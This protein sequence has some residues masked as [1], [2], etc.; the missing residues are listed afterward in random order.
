MA[1]ASRG[2][3]WMR[4]SFFPFSVATASTAHFYHSPF[5]KIRRRPSRPHPPCRP[6]KKKCSSTKR[7]SGACCKKHTPAN[8]KRPAKYKYNKKY[9]IKTKK[10]K[11]SAFQPYALGRPKKPAPRHNNIFNN[12]IPIL[13]MIS[14]QRTIS[15]VPY[16][17]H[18]HL[19][20][21]LQ[22]F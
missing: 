5:F 9:K 14:F 3:R 15:L 10:I 22:H 13:F 12:V 6:R 16:L 7:K 8:P 17:V 4:Q 21:F 20:P 19:P 18:R 1:S 11:H 2:K